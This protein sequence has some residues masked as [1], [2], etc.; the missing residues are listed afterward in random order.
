MKLSTMY[1]SRSYRN[2]PYQGS[3]NSL[4]L[5]QL[6]HQTVC[7]GPVS[8]ESFSEVFRGFRDLDY[9]AKESHKSL[10]HLFTELMRITSIQLPVKFTP[11]GEINV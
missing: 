6:V 5:L 2:L 8:L 10:I 11:P 7:E 9:T 3:F 1:Q 4:S